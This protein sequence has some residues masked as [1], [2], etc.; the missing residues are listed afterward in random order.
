MISSHTRCGP[1]K[2]GH[3]FSTTTGILTDLRTMLIRI[4]SRSE[5][6]REAGTMFFVKS[7][8]HIFAKLLHQMFAKCNIWVMIIIDKLG[9]SSAKNGVHCH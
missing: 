3:L 5:K 2:T 9:L 6:K 7:H 8:S 4:V 1:G